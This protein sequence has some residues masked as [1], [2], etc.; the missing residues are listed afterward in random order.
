MPIQVAARTARS[1]SPLSRWRWWTRE[2][3]ASASSV[4][5]EHQC[6][7]RQALEVVGLE[8]GV[9]VG[10]RERL[11]GIEPGAARKG[12]TGPLEPVDMCRSGTVGQWIARA[13]SRAVQR[14]INGRPWTTSRGSG[15][16]TRGGGLQA[17]VSPLTA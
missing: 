5:T 14:R 13:L 2:R 3:I 12:V 11:V 9:L 8:P 10:A 7:H 6:R 1:V 4:A 15:R 17:G 16:T